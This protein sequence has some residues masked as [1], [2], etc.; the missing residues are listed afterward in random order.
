MSEGSKKGRRSDATLPPVRGS[1]GR[2]AAVVGVAVVGAA[3]VLGGAED[4]ALGGR[5]GGS[6][7]FG[8]AA[9]KVMEEVP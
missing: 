6:L 3:V 9:M 5:G 7:V 4:R 1:G 8:G 2:V